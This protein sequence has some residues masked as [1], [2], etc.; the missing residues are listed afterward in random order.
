MTARTLLALSCLAALAAASNA[1]AQSIPP[2]GPLSVTFTVT[3][4]HAYQTDAHR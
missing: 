3:S 2:E 4:G 1:N